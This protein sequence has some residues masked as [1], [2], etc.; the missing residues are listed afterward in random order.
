MGDSE[1]AALKLAFTANRDL[2]EWS[3]LAVI[4]GLAVEMI[5]LW[6]FSHG[7]GES[8]S[9][10]IA[11]LIISIG[12]FGEYRFGSKAADAATELQRTSDERVARLGKDAAEAVVRAAT[13]EKSAAEAKL[14]LAKMNAPRVL[15]ESQISGLV[16]S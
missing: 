3:N 10:T 13:A 8:I 7:K 9:L 1:V 2:A 12:V 15:T 4:A 5:V 11:V 6:I 14:E 16:K